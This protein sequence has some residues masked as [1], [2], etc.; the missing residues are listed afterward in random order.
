MNIEA[1]HVASNI[2][3]NLHS[4]IFLVILL[5]DIESY[6]TVDNNGIFCL[7]LNKFYKNKSRE[8]FP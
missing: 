6:T 5:A 3:K 4:T 2:Y 7:M 1:S 8:V